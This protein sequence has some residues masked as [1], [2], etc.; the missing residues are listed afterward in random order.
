MSLPNSLRLLINDA[1]WHETQ[2]PG[3]IPNGIAVD[4]KLLQVLHGSKTALQ[5]FGHATV[6]SS[7]FYPVVVAQVRTALRFKKH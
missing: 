1:G 3:V 7:T 5:A 2:M 6:A 4:D